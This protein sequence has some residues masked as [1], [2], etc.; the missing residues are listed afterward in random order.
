V[1]RRLA[2]CDY[3]RVLV[4]G[5]AGGVGGYAVQLAK[6]AGATVLAVASS[7]HEDYLRGLGADHVFDYRTADVVAAVADSVGEV[8][9]VVDLVG[10]NA[11]VPALQVLRPYGRLATAVGLTGDFEL[12]V[13]K[14]HTLHGVLVA[15]D[16]QRLRALA[17]LADLGVLLPP[18][19]EVFALEEIVAAHTRTE[20]GHGRG[21]VVIDL[22]ER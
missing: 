10:T 12:A 9:A 21:K 6:R 2:V 20:R 8:D 15:P 13:D 11:S 17:E 4:Y 1:V 18:P 7:R 3:E 5:A 16:A 22:D 14:N 19:L